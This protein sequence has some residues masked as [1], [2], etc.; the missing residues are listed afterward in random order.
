MERIERSSSMVTAADRHVLLSRSPTE[1][2]TS[3]TLDRMAPLTP[4]PE[5]AEVE[6][7]PAILE[8]DYMV[9]VSGWHHAAYVRTVLAQGEAL[10]LDRSGLLPC[11]RVVDFFHCYLG[12]K[13]SF[14]SVLGVSHEEA[15]SG[16]R[17]SPRDGGGL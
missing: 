8:R 7:M 12:V 13:S 16:A 14:R 10:Q 2:I 5:V 17:A 3:D 6:G 9:H 11:V 4:R 15:I 1:T